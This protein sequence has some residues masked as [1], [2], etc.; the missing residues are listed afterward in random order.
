MNRF[1]K[2]II[3]LWLTCI[4]WMNWRYWVKIINKEETTQKLTIRNPS[5]EI[6]HQLP[7]NINCIVACWL[8][9][10]FPQ[11]FTRANREPLF[12]TA[13]VSTAVCCTS[14]LLRLRASKRVISK[15]MNDR[16]CQVGKRLGGRLIGTW[17]AETG[18]GKHFIWDVSMLKG[19]LKTHKATNIPE[20]S[21][22]SL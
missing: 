9:Y 14:T 7:S 15:F 12:L 4:I 8:V 5:F 3:N 16:L 22:T 19:E 13:L 11:T 2:Q 17:K 21:G 1:N 20:H 6:V 10:F 18:V